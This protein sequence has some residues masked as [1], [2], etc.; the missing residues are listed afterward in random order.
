MH[1]TGNGT[2]RVSSSLH[3]GRASGMIAGTT[4]AARKSGRK[5]GHLADAGPDAGDGDTVIDDSGLH[6][7]PVDVE[8]EIAPDLP[9]DIDVSSNE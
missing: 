7:R 8:I 2:Q 5:Q 9:L 6:D 4:N 1:E 3:T